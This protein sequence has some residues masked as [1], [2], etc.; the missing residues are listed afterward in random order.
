MGE[1]AKEVFGIPVWGWMVVILACGLGSLHERR[2]ERRKRERGDWS[3]GGGSG[4]DWFDSGSGD[5][6]GGD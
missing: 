3:T 2:T 1:L 6:G 5:C 4:G